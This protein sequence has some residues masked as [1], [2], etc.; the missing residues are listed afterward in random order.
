MH[1][2]CEWVAGC[3]SLLLRPQSNAEQGRSIK[4][5]VESPKGE[6]LQQPDFLRRFPRTNA[7]TVLH[8][9][10]GPWGHQ[11]QERHIQC[12]HPL[13]STDMSRGPSLGPSG[14][15]CI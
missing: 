4:L 6:L 8:H 10:N 11:Q 14:T 15:G 7:E 5:R 1:V 3:T 12:R 2:V 13:L 9:H